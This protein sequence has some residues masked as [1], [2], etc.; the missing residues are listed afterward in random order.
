VRSSEHE[1][2]LRQRISALSCCQTPE[3][4]EK[5]QKAKEREKKAARKRLIE[6]TITDAKTAV[7]RHKMAILNQTQTIR[8]DGDL[9]A[10]E[11]KLKQKRVRKMRIHKLKKKMSRME[12]EAVAL[13]HVG[14]AATLLNKERDEL[15]KLKNRTEADQRT[16]EH[17]RRSLQLKEQELIARQDAVNLQ[18]KMLKDQHAVVLR[19]LALLR[20]RAELIKQRLIHEG[21]VVPGDLIDFEKQ[22]DAMSQ[23][24]LEVSVEKASHAFTA[25]AVYRLGN[26]TGTGAES[27]QAMESDKAARMREE[28]EDTIVK[29]TTKRP[30]QDLVDENYLLSL[31]KEPS[32]AR[33]EVEQ[34]KLLP[35]KPRSLLQ[36]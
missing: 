2:R 18:A 27:L 4:Y 36:S 8:N 20:Q 32:L 24:R 13:T 12:A 21:I 15:S 6:K 28:R 5:Q 23:H 33:G 11:E 14:H 34:F 19:R 16:L 31:S 17:E 9:R 29:L 30:G 26:P 22:V 10:K 35:R 25:R 7:A 1:E 3:Q